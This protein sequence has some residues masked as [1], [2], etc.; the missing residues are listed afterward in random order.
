MIYNIQN[1]A[2]RN[3]SKSYFVERTVLNCFM[4]PKKN[5]QKIKIKCTIQLSVRVCTSK[6]GRCKTN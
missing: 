2:R 3:V 4:H 1:T 6:A 5:G